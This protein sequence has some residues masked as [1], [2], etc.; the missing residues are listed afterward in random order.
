MG[1]PVQQHLI[2]EL[3]QLLRHL[4]TQTISPYFFPLAIF[5]SLA[6]LELTEVHQLR[7]SLSLNIALMETRAAQ[8]LSFLLVLG[9]KDFEVGVVY[10]AYERTFLLFCLKTYLIHCQFGFTRFLF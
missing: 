9:L 7:V 8:I 1:S 10:H 2:L 3:I 5:L 6:E 4:E